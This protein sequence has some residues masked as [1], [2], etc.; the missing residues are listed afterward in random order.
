MVHESFHEYMHSRTPSIPPWFDEGLAEYVAA[1]RIENGKVVET[2]RMMRVRRETLRVAFEAGWPGTPF[3]VILRESLKEFMGLLPDLQ[4]AQAWSM[5]H[6]LIHYENGKYRPLFDA[7]LKGV[8]AGMSPEDLYASVFADHDLG[9]MRLQW[10]D[11]VS[12]LP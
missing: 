6:F 2:G 11:Y 8:L 7:Y 3:P 9:E 4:Y 1:I 12:K 10:I 5:V